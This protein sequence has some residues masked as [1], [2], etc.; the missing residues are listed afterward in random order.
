M[1]TIKLSFDIKKSKTY[2]FEN[3]FLAIFYLFV[4][5]ICRLCTKISSVMF[6]AARQS[7]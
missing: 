6:G 3:I 1:F 5:Q 2:Y 4:G 7:L